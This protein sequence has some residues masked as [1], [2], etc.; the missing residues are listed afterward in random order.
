MSTAKTVVLVLLVIAAVV[1][2]VS[3]VAFVISIARVIVELAILLVL[4][5][6]AWH[7]FLRNRSPKTPQ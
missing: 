5:Y 2:V 1:L 6:L 7:L 3:L 4:G